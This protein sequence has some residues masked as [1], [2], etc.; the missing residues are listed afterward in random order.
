MTEFTG[1]EV[2]HDNSH[3]Q[4]SSCGSFLSNTA[5]GMMKCESVPFEDLYNKGGTP[6]FLKFA[7]TVQQS[8]VFQ[9][10]KLLHYTLIFLDFILKNVHFKRRLGKI[11]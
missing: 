4:S 9:S 3:Q 6:W 8:H 5:K 11:N 7:N 10:P 2:L 1:S